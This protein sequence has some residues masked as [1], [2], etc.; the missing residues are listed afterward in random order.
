MRVIGLDVARSV[1]DVVQGAGR[2]FSRSKA[3]ASR[4]GKLR[5]EHAT[6]SA[7]RPFSDCPP[8]ADRAY[9]DTK[10]CSCAGTLA[11]SSSRLLSS[12]TEH[13]CC[14]GTACGSVSRP[15]PPPL[16]AVIRWH[17]RPCKLLC[18]RICL[19]RQVGEDTSSVLPSPCIKLK[20]HPI[21]PWISLAS[22]CLNILECSLWRGQRQPK[23]LI[24]R[25][26]TISS[27]TSDVALLS[28]FLTAQPNTWLLLVR[29]HRN[30]ALSGHCILLGRRHRCRC[31][32]LHFPFF[33][34][35][36][37][38]TIA[39]GGRTSIVEPCANYAGC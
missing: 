1:A 8:I 33:S 19:C 37:H 22:R 26:L 36:M 10:R 18:P 7:G 30:V 16:L 5:V 29:V 23:Y 15:T 24:P 2:H 21:F 35:Y 3:R 32:S 6:Y 31:S 17:R 14:S 28:S 25:A 34:G 12:Q 20:T 39:E 38:A 27:W 9:S 4:S 11:A 13:A